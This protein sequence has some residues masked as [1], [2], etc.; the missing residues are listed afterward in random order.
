MEGSVS[1][2]LGEHILGEGSC[3]ADCFP[4]GVYNSL[5]LRKGKDLDGDLP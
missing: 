5:A 4:A 2:P 1:L 3:A